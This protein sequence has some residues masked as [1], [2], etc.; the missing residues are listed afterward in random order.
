MGEITFTAAPLDM[1]EGLERLKAY[2]LELREAIVD[3]EHIIETEQ[4]TPANQEEYFISELPE[5]GWAGLSKDL[6]SIT[7]I[8]LKTERGIRQWKGIRAKSAELLAWEINE[9]NE[10]AR[11]LNNELST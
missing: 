11:T 10:K 9:K 7:R 3:L 4:I 8:V 1:R 6:F 5:G 2:A